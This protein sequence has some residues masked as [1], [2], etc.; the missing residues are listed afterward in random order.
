MR[1]QAPWRQRPRRPRPRRRLP[2]ASAPA[3]VYAAIAD[4]TRRRL[5]D[6]LGRGEK[7]VKRLA[8]PFAM[9]R[10]AVSQHLRILRQ[11]RL[12]AMRRAGR[13]HHYYLLALPLR[14]VHR[15][16]SHYEKFWKEK[17]AALRRFLDRDAAAEKDAGK[18]PP[19]KEADG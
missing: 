16:V 6:A 15:W 13:E 5:L 12:V 2:G 17:L 8:E 3:D 18:S 4:P 11:A 1:V 19:E 10:P 9:T 7:T 14:D